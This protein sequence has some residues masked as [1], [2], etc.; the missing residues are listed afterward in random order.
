MQ[1]S[2][3]L[4]MISD[5]RAIKTGTSVSHAVRNLYVDF[6][7]LYKSLYFRVKNPQETNKQKEN[8][9]NKTIDI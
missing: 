1:L 4:T 7:S 9:Q 5:L 2:I 6:A 8:K 3:T